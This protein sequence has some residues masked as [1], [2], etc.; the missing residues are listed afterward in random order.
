MYRH[1]ISSSILMDVSEMRIEYVR[2]SGSD[3]ER[4]VVNRLYDTPATYRYW[5]CFHAGL[6]RAVGDGSSRKGQLRRMRRTC[7]Q[8]IHR[9]ALFEFLRASS[10]T[11]KEREALFGVL[12]GTQDY[13]K[14]VVTEHGR[15]LQSNSSLFCADHLAFS[16]MRDIG[17]SSGLSLYRSRYL[18]YFGHYCSWILAESRGHDFSLGCLVP[19]LKKELQIL[20]HELL[21]LPAPIRPVMQ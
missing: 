1:A 2:W 7:F 17:F 13:A 8:L 15:Y 4:Q 18:E 11:G 6:M 9:Q 3:D 10:V 14:A 20:Q 21:A 12:H 16:V 5:E 19:H